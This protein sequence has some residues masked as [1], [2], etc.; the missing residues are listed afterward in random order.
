VAEPASAWSLSLRLTPS[1]IQTVGVTSRG[2]VSGQQALVVIHSSVGVSVFAVPLIAAQPTDVP[3]GLVS[4]LDKYCNTFVEID[5]RVSEIELKWVE[6][7]PF[8]VHESPA[9]RQWQIVIGSIS[10]PGTLTLQ[11][12]VAGAPTDE[13]AIERATD[14]RSPVSIDII[15]DG[16]QDFIVSH[17]ALGTT[18]GIRALQRWLLPLM[19]FQLPRPALRLRRVGDQIEIAMND[20]RTMLSTR[21]WD[22]SEPRAPDVVR[23]VGGAFGSPADAPI[24]APTARLSS[25]G[26]LAPSANIALRSI[27][28]RNGIVVAAYRDQVI[29]ATTYSSIRDRGSRHGCDCISAP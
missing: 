12:S 3:R 18:F 1:V 27:T 25:G 23:Q 22:L 2:N 7:P 13:A 11:P 20:R 5:R 26:V 19:F 28:L 10:A 6:P 24:D 16:G 21:S 29:V 17:S 9:L 14:G 15:A 8:Y 4:A